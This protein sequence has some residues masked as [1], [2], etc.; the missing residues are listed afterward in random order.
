MNDKASVS[1]EL[2]AKHSKVFPLIFYFFHRTFFYYI[3]IYTYNSF[4]FSCF[5]TITVIAI[6]FTFNLLECEE[7]MNSYHVWTNV[8]WL[9]MKMKDLS[10]NLFPFFGC[11]IEYELINLFQI[12]NRFHS[13]DI[14]CDCNS[15]GLRRPC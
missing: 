7:E 4:G 15:A 3:Y 11:I 13:G 5:S 8:D 10:L 9:M 14:D 2:S 6:S 1:K 12:F